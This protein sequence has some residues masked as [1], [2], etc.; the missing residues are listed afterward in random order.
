MAEKTELLK[1]NISN[2]NYRDAL[3]EIKKWLKEGG[4]KRYIVTPNPEIIIAAQRD[5]L[6]SK[7]LNNADLALPDGIGLLWASRIMGKPL[8][9]RVTGVDFM[10]K[11]CK[12]AAEEG[13]NVGLI[14]GKKQVAVKAAECLKK[15]YPKLKVVLAQEE[16]EKEE[17]EGSAFS[18]ASKD[19]R[20]ILGSKI[21][22]ESGS[23][24]RVASSCAEMRDI[25]S[26][27]LRVIPSRAQADLN[28][29]PY[30]IYHTPVDILFVAFGAPK[31]EIWISQNLANLPV[32]VAM[33]VGGAFDYFA[34]VV[35]RAPRW[36]R[37]LGL[38][39]L[40]R[41]VR[42]PWRI[43]RQFAL[44]RFISLVLKEKFFKSTT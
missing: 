26:L 14:G 8:K 30:T 11:L 6:L 27:P 12:L 16:W 33:G 17:S 22:M 1:I 15:R 43:E 13:L 24:S 20:S 37:S 40:F 31:Q 2:V 3:E 5:R 28:H 25:E 21:A 10:E 35:P 18:P 9:E 44:V 38:E 4:K 39:W 36:M 19:L 7:I 29:I 32:K 23:R 42:Q 34:G 41:L